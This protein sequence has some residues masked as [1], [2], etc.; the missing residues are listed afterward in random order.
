MTLE[1]I[2]SLKRKKVEIEKSII[3]IE[4]LQKRIRDLD[5][6]DFK[7]AIGKNKKL[8]IIGEV[9]KASPSKGVIREDFDPI[10]IGKIYEKNQI[11]AISVLTEENFF[12]GKDEYLSLIK[13]E[14]KIP[15]LRKDF[16]ID[17]YQIYQSK[18][19]GADAILLIGTLLTKRELIEFQK[20]AK[21]INLQCLVEVHNLEELGKV[22]ETGTEIIGINNRNLKTFEVTIETTEELIG[23][24]PK[25]KVVISESGI[26]NRKDMEYLK[27]IGV[28]GVLIGESFMKSKSMENKIKELRGE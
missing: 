15:I 18:E 28:D 6:R 9:K 19:L 5:T 22:L 13:K 10:S 27:S 20:I 11:N 14:T 24:I 12:L 16:I 25:D 3:S 8:N 7:G 17:S 26:S 1:K 21:D 2:V 4:N 23:Y